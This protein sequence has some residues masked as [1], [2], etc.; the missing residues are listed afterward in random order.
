[1]M[2][3]KSSYDA[4][5]GVLKRIRIVFAIKWKS[6]PRRQNVLIKPRTA[7]T[8]KQQED[9]IAIACLCQGEWKIDMHEIFILLGE[10]NGSDT[11]NVKIIRSRATRK[12][13]LS[14]GVQVQMKSWSTDMIARRN[15]PS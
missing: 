1:M 15:R 6:P 9:N 14:P 4:R 2:P 12:L 11:L 13:F 3:R 7:I 5:A 10:K 8:N